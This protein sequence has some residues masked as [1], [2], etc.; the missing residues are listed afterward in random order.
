MPAK[1]KEPKKTKEIKPKE[2]LDPFNIISEIL[3][4]PAHLMTNPVNAEYQCPYINSICTKRSGKYT[5]AYPV[6]SIFRK[7]G[8][9][10]HAA[11][12]PIIM[13]PKR[14][15][16]ADIVNDVIKYAW[17]GEPPE[18]PNFVHEIRMKGVG[19]VDF[20]IADLDHEG[21]TIRQFLSVELQA[22]DCT[23]SVEPAYT[24][25][26]NSQSIQG[27]CVY[28]FN[29]AN[30]RKRFLTQL[31]FKGFFH[32]HWKTKIVAIVQSPIY[33]NIKDTTGLVESSI[34][35]SNVIF[36]QYELQEEQGPDGTRYSLKF[37]QI[38]GTT[39]NSLM[40]TTLYSIAPPREDFCRH[41]LKHI[42]SS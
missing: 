25:I 19:N 21:E 8:R 38:K 13:C 39:V 34:P 23:G 11:R 5:G 7:V 16:E 24:A 15:Y 32:H 12:K 10:P 33:Q 6:C 28:N 31:I 2:P 22:I 37:D 35:D 1:S 27:R 36:L 29:W 26:L 30:V 3:G 20:V 17:P 4:E 40:N 18:H 14:F 41:I 9:G 42:K